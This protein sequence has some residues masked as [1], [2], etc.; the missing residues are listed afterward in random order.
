MYLYLGSRV[1]EWSLMRKND[2]EGEERFSET[3]SYSVY[4]VSIHTPL[5]YAN[6]FWLVC[7]V[8]CSRCISVRVLPW[9]WSRGILQNSWRTILF[10]FPQRWSCSMCVYRKTQPHPLCFFLNWWN[11]PLPAA[12][13]WISCL[14][15]WGFLKPVVSFPTSCCLKHQSRIPISKYICNRDWGQNRNMQ[16]PM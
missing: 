16:F 14:L 12:G 11:K 9:C 13:D 2:R 5:G 15:R 3:P 10:V 6:G 1:A 8:D 4:L 7:L